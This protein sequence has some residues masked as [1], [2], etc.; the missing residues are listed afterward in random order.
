MME[1]LGD[2]YGTRLPDIRFS[3]SQSVGWVSNVDRLQSG[4]GDVAFT[5]SD[6]A[7]TAFTTGTETNPTPHTKLRG[8]AVMW[9]VPLHLIVGPRADFHG[10]KDLRGKRV[11][12]GPPGSGT[13][14]TTR[15]IL[16]QLGIPL[17]EVHLESMPAA[18]VPSHLADGTIDAE[19]IMG[20]YPSDSVTLA[21]AVP[22][23]RLVPI[24]GFDISNLKARYPFLRSVVIPANV[25]AQ[26]EDIDSVGV[27]IL[28]VCRENLSEEIVYRMLS[29][30][31]DGIQELAQ[32]QRGFQTV[33]V[34]R[35]PAT[36]IPLHPGA[37]RFYREHQLFN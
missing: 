35:A 4:I 2:F 21:L 37:A 32:K 12:F 11:G 14:V 13:E 19:F 27:D 25:Y 8:L 20:A 31:F 3:L 34:Q 36:P 29:T 1:A 23:T 10:V 6:I 22:G 7:Y 28:F 16:G 18:Q 5:Q 33:S 15:V 26:P 30:L 24:R 17:S 9:L